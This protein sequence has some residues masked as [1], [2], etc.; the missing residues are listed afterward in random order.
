MNPRRLHR[1]TIFSMRSVCLASAISGRAS[2]IGGRLVTSAARRPASGSRDA[3]TLSESKAHGTH[4]GPKTSGHGSAL[5][6]LQ[7]AVACWTIQPQLRLSMLASYDG[8]REQVG[9][10]RFDP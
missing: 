4:S 8:L 7:P 10:P 6:E 9:R 2:V 1:E 3:P 5:R